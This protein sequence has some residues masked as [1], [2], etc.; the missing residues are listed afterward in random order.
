M[1]SGIVERK[2]LDGSSRVD[3][4][5]QSNLYHLQR[6]LLITGILD[7]QLAQGTHSQHEWHS[8]AKSAEEDDPLESTGE[9][10]LLYRSNP[11]LHIIFYPGLQTVL[12]KVIQAVFHSIRGIVISS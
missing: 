11:S 10:D 5:G 6:R 3:V 8:Q 7:Q 1:S 12:I 9:G 4:V 2:V